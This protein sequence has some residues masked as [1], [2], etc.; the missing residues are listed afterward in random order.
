MKSNKCEG[1]WGILGAHFSTVGSK[2][3]LFSETR[4]FLFREKSNPSSS[5][6]SSKYS[7]ELSPLISLL[8]QKSDFFSQ[9]NNFF[10]IKQLLQPNKN[11]LPSHTSAGTGDLRSQGDGLTTAPAEPLTSQPSAKTRQILWKAPANG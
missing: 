5:N 6:H 4:K 1:P 2:G 7:T 3:E 11:H 8:E 10:S 9:F